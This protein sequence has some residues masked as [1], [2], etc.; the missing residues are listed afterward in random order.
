M[1]ELTKKLI[2]EEEELSKK[3]ENLKA[4]LQTDTY[5]NLSDIEKVNLIEQKAYMCSY[6][7]IL[8]KRIRF[9]ED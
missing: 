9:Y 7:Y 1:L 5:K 2:K 8:K 4:F 6:R 3:I